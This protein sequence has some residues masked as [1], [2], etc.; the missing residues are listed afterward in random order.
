MDNPTGFFKQQGGM[1]EA[2]LRK[3]MVKPNFWRFAVHARGETYSVFDEA[4]D[5]Q[6]ED[7]QFRQPG[8]NRE[9]LYNF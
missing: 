1:P 6:V 9:N 5:F 8:P 4:S 3:T 2:S 7:S